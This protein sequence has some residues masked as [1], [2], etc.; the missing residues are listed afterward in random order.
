MNHER[1]VGTAHV[2]RLCPVMVSRRCAGRRAVKDF[3]RD[4]IGVGTGSVAAGFIGA[5]AVD[6]SPPNT[7]IATASGAR[8]QRTKQHGRSRRAD[9]GGG[10]RPPRSPMY[11]WRR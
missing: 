1:L 6:A 2:A 4:L 8:T 3:N 5:L 7:A 11:H 9:R 10:V